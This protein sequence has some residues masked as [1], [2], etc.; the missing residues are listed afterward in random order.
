MGLGKGVKP[1]GYHIKSLAK[2]DTGSIKIVGVF[3]KPTTLRSSERG[4]WVQNCVYVALMCS[5]CGY[6][7]V[8]RKKSFISNKCFKCPKCSYRLRYTIETLRE[9]YEKEFWSTLKDRGDTK[10]IIPDQEYKSMNTPMTFTCLAHGDFVGTAHDVIRGNKLC[11]KCSEIR[12]HLDICDIKKYVSRTSKNEYV[13]LTD[14]YVKTK[15][16]LLFE[17]VSLKYKFKLSFQE[18]KRG[19]RCP[20]FSMPISERIVSN[21][22]QENKIE[23][24]AQYRINGKNHAHFYDFYLPKYNLLVEMQGI[25]HYGLPADN[26]YSDPDRPKW[27]EEKKQLA[28]DHNLQLLTIPYTDFTVPKICEYFNDM[29]VPIIAKHTRDYISDHTP[30]GE[31]ARYYRNHTWKDTR[32][33]YGVSWETINKSFKT[34]Y[35]FDKKEYLSKKQVI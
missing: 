27:D 8:Q 1:L 16:K 18:Y 10:L 31:I 33:K 11:P 21:L 26:M 4:T 30:Y 25:Q 2:L 34:L 29:N 5:E 12:R 15:D 17:Y 35:G 32:K 22:L 20:L 19:V 24:N 13:V 3:R 6:E 14:D 9:K 28:K 7:W 23:Y